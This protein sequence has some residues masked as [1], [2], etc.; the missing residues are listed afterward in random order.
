MEE[1]IIELLKESKDCPK[2]TISIFNYLCSKGIFFPLKIISKD[3]NVLRYDI[4]K[5]DLLFLE[6]HLLEM[7]AKKL[8]KTYPSQNKKVKLWIY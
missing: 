4:K 6:E 8:I 5:N 1:F 3:G 2:T 7:V